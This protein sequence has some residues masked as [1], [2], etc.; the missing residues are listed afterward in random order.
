MAAQVAEKYSPYDDAPIVIV[1][2]DAKNLAD[3]LE[4]KVVEK[5]PDAKIWRQPIGPVIGAHCGP[6]TVGIIFP[7]TGR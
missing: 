5:F 6:G 7:A 1:D 4:A 2:A 3:E